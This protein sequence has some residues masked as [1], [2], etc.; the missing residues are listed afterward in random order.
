[1]R[2]MITRPRADAERLAALLDDRGIESLIEPLLEITFNA[3]PPLDLDGVRA[4]LLTSANGARALGAA[5]ARRRLCCR[6]RLAVAASVE[7]SVTGPRE[8]R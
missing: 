3:D 2:V 8:A 6:G 5:T 1:M 4:L 7:W